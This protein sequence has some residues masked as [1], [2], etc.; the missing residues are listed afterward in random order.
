MK[1]NR[2]RSYGVLNLTPAVV[3]RLGREWAAVER[4]RRP[5]TALAEVADGLAM[6]LLRRSEKRPLAA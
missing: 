4:P 2:R 5:A 6:V 1:S 3:G